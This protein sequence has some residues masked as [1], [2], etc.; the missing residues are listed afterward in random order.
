MIQNK[1]ISAERL[2]RALHIAT[3]NND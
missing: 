3:H 1:K 2:A